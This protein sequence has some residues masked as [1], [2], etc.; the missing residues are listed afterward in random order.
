M[1]KYLQIRG[2]EQ[3]DAQDVST[4]IYATSQACCF[5]KELPCPGWFEES[6]NADH[7]SQCI[8]DTEMEWLVAVEDIRLVGVLAVSGRNHIKYFFV[9]P[10]CQ[11]RGIGKALWDAADQKGVF[12]ESLVVR[13]SLNA[14]PVYERLGFVK[15]DSPKYFNGLHYQVMVSKNG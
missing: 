12:G 1:D 3:I 14:V 15:V 13:S 4:L 9:H 10:S 11:S 8:N 6:V 7:I 2:A 5:T